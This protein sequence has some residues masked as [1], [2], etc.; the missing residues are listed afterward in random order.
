MPPTFTISSLVRVQ[1]YNLL[2]Y[3]TITLD[4]SKVLDGLFIASNRQF[5]PEGQTINARNN[6]NIA[7]SIE[8][9]NPH[10]R[11]IR[12]EVIAGDDGVTHN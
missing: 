8:F 5:L 6:P 7:W 2:G 4:P 1:Q 12:N 3:G 9:N 10:T 11:L